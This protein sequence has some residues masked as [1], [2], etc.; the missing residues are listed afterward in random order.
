[1]PHGDIYIPDDVTSKPAF[2][3][4]VQEVLEA[5]LENDS[6]VTNCSNASALLYHAFQS[7]PASFG[8]TGEG[9]PVV[10]WAGE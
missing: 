9:A 10:N 2:Y 6:F 3:A 4:H 7:Y 1:M 5:L 8:K